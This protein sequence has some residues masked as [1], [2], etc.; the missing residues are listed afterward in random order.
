MEELKDL[1]LT[2]VVVTGEK[3]GKGSYGYVVGLKVKGLK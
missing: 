3:I 1:E 2:D